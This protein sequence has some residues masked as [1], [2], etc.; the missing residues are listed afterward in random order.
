MTTQ[1]NIDRDHTAVLIMDY[2]N[3]IVGFVSTGQAELLDRAAA[4]L[5]GAR[6]AG[7]PVIH[8]VIS[9]RE[10][11]PEI[12]PRNKQFSPLKASGMLQTGTDGATVHPR[13]AP[14]PGEMIVNRPRAG[15]FFNSELETI[16]KVRGITNL[17]LFGIATSGVTLS[18]VRE[19]GDAD[20]DMIVLADCCFDF[21][22][23]V[24]R[25]LTQKVFPSQA[26]VVNSQDFLQA[27]GRA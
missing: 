25:V 13:V 2:Q 10:G 27:I 23:E 19:A 11:H 22:E 16:L 3:T 4:V 26:T 17:V 12:S 21:D 1:L 6:Q 7:I 20:Y 24:H 9:F 5:S 8:V 18:T 15:S 14:Q